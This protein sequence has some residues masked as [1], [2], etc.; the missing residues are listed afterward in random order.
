LLQ[1]RTQVL[2]EVLRNTFCRW[3]PGMQ[4]PSSEAKLKAAA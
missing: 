1:V 4:L 3:C 2:N